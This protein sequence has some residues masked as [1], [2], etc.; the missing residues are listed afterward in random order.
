M[1]KITVRVG[2]YDGSQKDIVFIGELLK[3]QQE[4]D[5]PGDK[6]R[7]TEYTLYRVP[8]GYKVYERRWANGQG[9]K[10]QNYAKFSR[11]YTQTELLEKFPL[12]ANYAG[13]F[14][15]EEV[16]DEI[17][18][19]EKTILLAASTTHHCILNNFFVL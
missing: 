15:T 14:E 13:I 4:F 8:N 18:E 1:E 19:K 10:R 16:D 6:S 2:R 3:T 11:V 5:A 12:L 7:G 17:S 9:Q